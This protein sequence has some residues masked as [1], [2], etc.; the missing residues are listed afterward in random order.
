MTRQTWTAALSAVLFVVLA[1]VIALVPVPYVTWAP[2]STYDLLSNAGQQDAI[3]ITG[4]PTYP[5]EGELRMTTISVTASDSRLSLPEVLISYWMPARAVLPRDAVYRAGA[6]PTEVTSQESQLMTQSQT[7]AVVAALRAANVKVTELP[8][9]AS[10]QT[11][12]PSVGLLEPGDLITAV[13]NAEVS[14]RAE[15]AQAIRGRHVG[16]KAVFTVIRNR[17]TLQQTVTTRATPSAPNDPVVGIGISTG[18][19]YEPKVSFKVDPDVGGSSA[20]LMF[21]LAIFDRTTPGNLVD[22][23]IVGGTGTMAADGQVGTVGGVEE[24]LAAA[25]RDQATIFLLPKSNCSNVHTVPKGVRL[26]A[27]D[28]LS[29]AIAALRALSDPSTAASARG[30]S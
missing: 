17:E 30:C 16:Q 29:E 23:R 27:V 24:K 20:G 7:S 15:V 11:S 19:L 13:D 14:T 12:G 28:T 22:G 3:E 5:T 1:A 26:V 4:I 8:M 21:A 10:V 6:S 25:A 2:G 9:V 18:Y